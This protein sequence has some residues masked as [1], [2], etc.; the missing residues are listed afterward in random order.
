MAKTFT[1]LKHPQMLR[2]T[3]IA[4][5]KSSEVASWWKP[6]VR[7]SRGV[8]YTIPAKIL[9]VID[10]ARP[11]QPAQDEY[12]KRAA[13][14]LRLASAASPTLSEDRIFEQ[15]RDQM[16]EALEKIPQCLAH[17]Q[18]TQPMQRRAAVIEAVAP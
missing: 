4:V 10:S 8:A 9:R 3:T 11:S 6:W 7:V 14:S 5:R 18:A 1:F 2:S 16:H 17:L 15:R 13:E 12:V